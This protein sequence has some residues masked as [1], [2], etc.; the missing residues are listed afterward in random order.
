MRVPPPSLL[1]LAVGLALAMASGCDS[2]T[3]PS[4]NLA[5]RWTGTWQF[6]AGGATVTDGV[7]A[8]LTQSASGAAGSWTAASGASGEMTIAAGASISGTFSI[9]QTTFTGQVC[10]GSAAL[11]GSATSSSLEFSVAAIPGSG[12]CQWATDMQ[13]SLRR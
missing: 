13:F 12:A 9:A 2:P 8:T 1:T 10:T 11:T 3:S 4:V 6:R 5:G 7:V